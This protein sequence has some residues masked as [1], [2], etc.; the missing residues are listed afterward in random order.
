[1]KVSV[2]DAATLSALRPLEVVSYLRSTGWSKAAEQPN[3]VSIWLFRDAAGEEF[4]IALPLSHSFRDFALRMGDA[5]RTLEAVENRSQMEILRDLLVTSADV[6]RVRLIDSEPADGSLPLEDGAQFFLRA[7]EMVLA[8]ACAASGPRAYYPSKKPT[9]AMEYLRKARLGQ[10]EQGSF[11]LTI[12]SPVAPSLSGENGHPFEIDDPFERR[13]TL[14]LASALAATRIAAEAAA[15]SGSLQ[16]F[17]EAVPKGVSA[18]LCDSLVGMTAQS[19]VTHDLELAFTWSRSRPL[20]PETLTP[21]KIIV[22]ADAM[23]MIDEAARYFKE[24]SPREDFE[25]R[26]PVVRL[27]RAEGAPVGRVTVLGFVDQQPRKVK[28]ELGDADYH[29]AVVAHDRQQA[30][31][32]Y[33]V[34]VREGHSFRVSDPHDFLVIADD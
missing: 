13:V 12:I 28:I 20:V 23:P 31:S 18:N 27:E 22:P 21:N 16:S 24:T 2:R 34:L 19:G 14:T 29:R 26:G 30:V 7:K 10:T 5:L 9:Q 8:A 33:G 3:R 11:V 1:M 17:I 15:S 4:E 32:C 6:V 25:L